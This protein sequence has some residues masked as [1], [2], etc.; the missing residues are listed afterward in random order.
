VNSFNPSKFGFL[1]VSSAKPDK[2]I[3]EETFEEK[4][5]QMA[6]MDSFSSNI[7]PIHVLVFEKMCADDVVCLSKLMSS[8]EPDSIFWNKFEETLYR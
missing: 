4:V 7:F 2:H 3:L 1:A 8:A 6:N 5:V